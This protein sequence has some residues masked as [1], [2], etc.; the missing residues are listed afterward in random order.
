M[1][2]EVGWAPEWPIRGQIPTIATGLRQGNGGVRVVGRVVFVVTLAGAALAVAPA[3]DATGS[4]P[5]QVS[6]TVADQSAGTTTG[7]RAVNYTDD[8]EFAP[9]TGT[10]EIHDGQRSYGTFDADD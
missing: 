3:A 8:G 4:R 2:T 10:I 9:R 5:T 7:R 1:P 6:L